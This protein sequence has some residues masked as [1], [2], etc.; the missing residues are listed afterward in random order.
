V[1]APKNC[2]AEIIQKLSSET[3]AVVADPEFQAQLK[4]M[5]NTALS[6]TPAEFGRLIAE[7]SDKWSKVIAFAG[8]KPE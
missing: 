7:D 8:I 4:N 5:G 1:V 6:D 2:P 3:K